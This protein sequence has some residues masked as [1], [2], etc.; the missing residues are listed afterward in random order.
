MIDALPI[1][2]VL[3]LLGVANGMPVLARKLLRDRFGMPV[4][5]GV[6]LPDGRPLFGASKTIRGLVLSVASTALAA[7]LIGPDAATGALLA[8]ASMLG[9]LASS[10]VKRRLGLGPHAQAF[11]L[12]QIP[13]AL[14]PMLLLPASLGLSA[15]DIAVALA[16]FILLEMALSRL[17]FRLGIRDRPY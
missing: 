4:D 8:A 17:L 10:F 1:L 9:D 2:R 3:L 16:A 6:T 14:L 15:A 13:E 12:D 11:G 5:G 7:G